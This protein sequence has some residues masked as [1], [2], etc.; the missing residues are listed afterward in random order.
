MNVSFEYP[1]SSAAWPN[2]SFPLSYNFEA[3][4]IFASLSS[5]SAVFGMFIVNVFIVEM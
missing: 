3:N 4:D 1:A 5:I 2:V